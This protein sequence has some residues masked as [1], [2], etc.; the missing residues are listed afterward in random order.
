MLLSLV[1]AMDKS[2]YDI[3][4]KAI[5]N[6]LDLASELDSNVNIQAINPF[7]SVLLSSLFGYCIRRILPVS[8]TAK[9]L[10]GENYDYQ[11]AFLEGEPTY[12]L[13][14]S[15]L[16]KERKIAWVHVNLMDLF[17]S[18]G[19]YRSINDHKRVYESYGKIICVSEDSKRA[20]R[21]R[22]GLDAE[23]IYNIFDTD[24]INKKA[25]SIP[26]IACA[27]PI[28][29]AM[30]VIMVGNCRPEK[31]YDRIIKVVRR[32]CDDGYSMNLTICG[33][34]VEYQNLIGLVQQ[35]KLQ[36]HV[37]LLG[38]VQNP[39]PYMKNADLFVCGSYSEALSSVV[40][41][42]IIIGTP[43]LTTDIPS[44]HEIL[45][46]RKYG[47]IVP[48]NEEGLYI[49]LKQIIE[50]PDMLEPYRTLLKHRKSFFSKKNTLAKIDE[51]L[52]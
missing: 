7:K 30:N 25:M 27:F 39:Y 12:I 29:D 19:L 17:S 5:Y 22:F 18:Q 49:G 28:S 24:M 50:H 6:R 2:K 3:T 1:N 31:G 32:L 41:E 23:V 26:E 51:L 43:V 10:I 33:N 40:I 15:K 36:N 20:F 9:Y 13:S 37:K 16:P 38:E 35:L 11:I 34:G 14:G 4:I 52:S 44:M 21:Q 45:D 47:I 42:A 46:G 48:N 8:F